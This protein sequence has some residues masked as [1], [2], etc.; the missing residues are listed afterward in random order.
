MRQSFVVLA[1]VLTAGV[2]C[3]AEVRSRMIEFPGM[4]GP[5]RAFLTRPVGAEPLPPIVMIHE[6][7]GLTPWV[8]AS[9][10]RLAERG[11]VVLVV[12]VYKGRVTDDPNVALAMMRGLDPASAVADLRRGVAFLLG[13]PGIDA[14]RKVGAIGWDMGGGL[15]RLLAESSDAIGPVAICSGSVTTDRAEVDR[16]VGK[17]VL[18]IFGDLDVDNPPEVVRQFGRMLADRQTRFNLKIYPNV[19]HSFMRP[20]NPDYSP[21]M[22]RAAWVAIEEF[23]S[24]YLHGEP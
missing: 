3:A 14:S 8:R 23:F 5:V 18:G 9:A 13:Q 1:G 15:A 20:D 16:L 2:A 11:Y 4:R 10:E 22:A 21:D 12:D 24:V 17:P 19:G 7:W 6:R